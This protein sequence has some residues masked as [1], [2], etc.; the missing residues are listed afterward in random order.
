MLQEV[1]Q[2]YGSGDLKFETTASFGQDLM[3][4]TQ[5]QLQA[6]M[7]V[8]PDDELREH[9][10]T[11]LKTEIPRSMRILFLCPT[12]GAGLM[13]VSRLFDRVRILKTPVHAFFLFR[14]LMD[15]IA[16]YPPDKSQRSPRYIT[17]QTVFIAHEK[18]QR[19]LKAH[20]RNL[21]MSGMYFEIQEVVAS[22]QNGDLITAEIDIQGVR[23][24]HFHAKIVWCKR[25]T[26]A[27]RPESD[28]H[29]RFGYGCTFLNREQVFDTLLS[30]A[31]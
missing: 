21:S 2:N 10:F 7:I 20:M 11:K 1:Y 24:H 23:T 14:N 4:W 6:L 30:G 12:I 25:V 31:R 28:E 13:Q 9:Y 16:E 27:G 18:N 3:W 5:H 29:D 8:L 15:L 17:D 22:L 19:R 26:E